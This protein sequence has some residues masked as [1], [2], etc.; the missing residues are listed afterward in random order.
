MKLQLRTHGVKKLLSPLIFF[1]FGIKHQK[2]RKEERPT[3]SL[4]LLDALPIN[5]ITSSSPATFCSSPGV[6]II[7]LVV[8]VNT[9]T[10]L[11]VGGG[12][13]VA[14]TS[15]PLSLRVLSK[16]LLPTHVTSLLPS[17]SSES[18]SKRLG[19]SYYGGGGGGGSGGR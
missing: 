2:R 10:T 17:S 9:G 15:Y 1:P 13:E 7:I 14:G 5:I 12:G 6:A 16:G 18:M 3:N 19:R 11:S 4:L 8:E